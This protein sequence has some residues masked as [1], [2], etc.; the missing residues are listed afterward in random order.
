MQRDD[1]RETALM[2][3]T[4]VVFIRERSRVLTGPL[5]PKFAQN[6]NFSRKLPENCMI[7]Q[8]SWQDMLGK[9]GIGNLALMVVIKPKQNAGR[10][11]RVR[12]VQ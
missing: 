4:L 9:V 2:L 12:L 1:G 8:K 5:S 7:L 11:I 10:K 3:S 6:R